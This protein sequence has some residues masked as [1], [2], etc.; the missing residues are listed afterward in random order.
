MTHLQIALDYRRTLDPAS[1]GWAAVD[2]LITLLIESG[3]FTFAD[4]YEY[5]RYIARTD[6]D[7]KAPK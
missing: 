5:Q 3:T 4:A 2:G 1:P 7:R 6:S